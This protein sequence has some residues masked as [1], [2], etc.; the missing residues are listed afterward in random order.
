MKRI[1]ALLAL[2]AVL[3]VALA[4]P[5]FAGGK[6]EA[7][8]AQACLNH[9][10]AMKDKGWSGVDLDKSDMTA[11]KV[12][13]VAPGSPGAKAGVQAGDVL[14]ALNGASLTDM[15]ALKKAKGDWSVGQSVTYTVKRK[16]ADKQIALKLDKMPEEVFASMIGRHMLDA[17]L[18]MASAAPA[19][20]AP[21]TTAPAT[22]P[23]TTTKTDK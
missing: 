8:D 14:V 1:S 21:A 22:A 18:A 13:A 10:S 12:K 3:T 2:F 5:A 16:N 19:D 11:I 6:C 9:M 20:P 17:H 7:A 4:V 23:A 15:E